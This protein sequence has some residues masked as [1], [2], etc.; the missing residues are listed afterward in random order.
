LKILPQ[1]NNELGDR[2]LTFNAVV[3]LKDEIR[4]V[5]L[6]Q[7]AQLNFGDSRGKAHS[8]KTCRAAYHSLRGRNHGK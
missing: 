5:E 2:Q 7:L 3:F 1:K 8:P 6:Q 4:Y